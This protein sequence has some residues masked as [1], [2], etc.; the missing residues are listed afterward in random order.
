M[1]HVTIELWTGE[2]QDYCVLLD[3]ESQFKDLEE[4]LQRFKDKGMLRSFSIEGVTPTNFTEFAETLLTLEMNYD[5]QQPF[6]GA[7]ARPRR[8]QRIVYSNPPWV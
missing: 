1:P 7:P 6:M 3:D 4:G 8:R 5:F 2:K